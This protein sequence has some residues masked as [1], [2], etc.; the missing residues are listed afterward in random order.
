MPD[1]EK[2]PQPGGTAT[3]AGGSM[4]E[5]I[6]W[7][8][9]HMWPPDVEPPGSNADA[10]AAIQESTGE[11]I[12]STTVWKLR[13]GRTGNPR[14]KT[15]KAL[16]AFFKVPIGYFG[17]NEDAEATAD[18][19]ALLAVLRDT[20]VDR[21][22]LRALVDLSDEGRQMVAEFL[23]SAARMEQRRTRRRTSLQK[24]R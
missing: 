6:D 18:Q 22:S 23:A 13:T 10:A 3:P 7:L 11:E 24:P 2:A 5:K 8:F 19:L 21:S 1:E 9:Q 12:S 14:F 17:E 4:A 15:L 16:S 20:G